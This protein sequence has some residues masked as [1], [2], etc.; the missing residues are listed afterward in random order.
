VTVLARLDA[1]VLAE[2]ANEDLEAFAELYRR[3]LC[4]IYRF[5]RA[6]VADE[7][8]A[9]D[10]TAQVFFRALRS[11]GTFRG[12]GSYESWLFRI[13]QNSVASWYKDRSR[14]DIAVERV[15]E[16]ADP[17]PSPASHLI[18]EEARDVLW[19]TVAQLPSTQREV[20]AM[21]YLSDLSVDE[22]AKLTRRSRGAVRILLHR[23]RSKLRKV[24]GGHKR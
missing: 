12:E 19:R 2:R 23:A 10:I 18:L 14:G 22:I 20:V 21:R 17:S 16:S 11:A 13:A 7:A 4:P 6:Q 3:Y 24:L 8:T 5:V 1:D 9:E 15:P